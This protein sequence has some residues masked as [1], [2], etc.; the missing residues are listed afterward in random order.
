MHFLW[1]RSHN[2]IVWSWEPEMT[3]RGAALS[4]VEGLADARA[5]LNNEMQRQHQEQKHPASAARGLSDS[6]RN[7]RQSVCTA[8]LLVVQQDA[9]DAGQEG[10]QQSL[11]LPCRVAAQTD[12]RVSSLRQQGCHGVV[13][14]REHMNVDLRPDVPHPHRRVTSPGHEHIDGW[15]K[16]KTEDSTEMPVVI[17][18]DL[19][20]RSMSILHGN[21]LVGT[22]PLS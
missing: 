19:H 8:Q 12:L 4:Q 6:Q 18:D 3:C 11:G 14:A 10:P 22:A 20:M 1:R 21:R 15:V 5:E 7:R 9:R 17:P 16:R 2:L 13:M